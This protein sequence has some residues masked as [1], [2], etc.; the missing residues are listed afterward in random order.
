MDYSY[1]AYNKERKVIKGK[2]SAANEQVALGLLNNSGYQVI[3]IQIAQPFMNLGKVNFNFSPKVKLSD[4]LFFSRQ[5]AIL[6]ESGIDI[7]RALELLQGQT[8]NTTLR[9]VIGEITEDIREGQSLS[10]ALSK[11]PDVF[12]NIYHRAVGAGEHGG[13]LDIILRQVADFL[14]RSVEASKK[15]KNAMMYPTVV[16]IIAIVVVAVL[17]TFVLPNFVG[18]FTAFGAEMPTSAKILFAISDWGSKYG[19]YAIG[20]I[21][22][23]AIA[24]FLYIKTAAGAYFWDGLSLRLPVLGRVNLLNQLSFCCRIMSLLFRVGLPT[25]EIMTMAI[26]STN[27]RVIAEA[28]RGVQE[29]M[30]RG[31]GI[32]RPMSRRPVFL[33]LMVQMI[34]VGEETGNMDKTL[35]TVAQSYEAEADERTRMLIAM[36]QPAITLV[37]GAVVVFIAVALVQSM[38]GVYGQIQM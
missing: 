9:K 20:A 18:L 36:L 15:M 16:A 29:E 1:T 4:V 11:H 28:L 30:I 24:G 32:S 27:N 25:P 19:L 2:V 6:V 5:L 31:E 14:E 22:I 17:T 13:N 34:A 38:Y 3:K 7:M 33:P 10:T 21:V 37:L 35:T 8:N 23:A 26:G 12:P